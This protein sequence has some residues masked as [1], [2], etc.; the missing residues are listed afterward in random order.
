MSIK[1]KIAWVDSNVIVEGVRVYKNS[2]LF[3]TNSLP[4][5]YAEITD[6]SLFYEDFDVIEG[7][8]YFYMLSCFLGEQEVFTECFEVEAV[9]DVINSQ[10]FTFASFNPTNYATNFN[11]ITGDFDLSRN[12][13]TYDISSSTND[14]KVLGVT[15]WVDFSDGRKYYYELIVKSEVDINLNPVL[16]PNLMLRIGIA[17]EGLHTSLNSSGSN[18]STYFTS[19]GNGKCWMRRLNENACAFN[20]GDVGVIRSETYG[21]DRGYIFNDVI[22]VKAYRSAPTTLTIEYYINGAHLATRSYAIASTKRFKP[23]IVYQ[24]QDNPN[25]RIYLNLPRTLSHRPADSIPWPVT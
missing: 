10:T 3:D 2:T 5:I 13:S 8:T 14:L 1:L 16:L 17:V 6:G 15:P 25:S 11:S 4:A 9:I 24:L 23:L 22:G 12:P 21:G 20:G 18:G 19:E 7:N